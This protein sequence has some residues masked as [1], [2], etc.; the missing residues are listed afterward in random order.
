MNDQQ[1]FFD[2]LRQAQA[3]DPQAREQCVMRN[4]GLVWSIVNRFQ[5]HTSSQDLFQIGCLGLMKAINNFDMRYQVMF[6]TYAVPIILGEIKRYFRD[7]GQ[8]KI[9]RSLKERYLQVQ[10]ARE[11]LA[12]SLQREATIRE[13]AEVLGLQETEVMLAL[14]ANQFLASMDEA[15]YQKDGS[16]IR[17]EDKVEDG[18]SEDV[19][20]KV[21]L[22]KEIGQLEERERYLIYLRYDLEYNQEAIARKMGIS[23]VQVS[24]LE[25]KILA[26]LKTKLTEE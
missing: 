2:L 26:K 15:F 7:E 21:A 6:S 1:E 12:Q 14:E 9:S 11:K 5:S 22:K 16:S 23:Q 10:K 18:H 4:L 17:L 20:L 13:I 24:R 3:G 25:K 19:P 8:M